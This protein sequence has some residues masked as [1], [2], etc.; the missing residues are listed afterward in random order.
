MIFLYNGYHIIDNKLWNTWLGKLKERGYFEGVEVN[1]EEYRERYQKAK[2]KFD[3]KFNSVKGN[4]SNEK[5]AEEFKL[6]GNQCLKDGEYEKAV[7]WYKKAIERCGAGKNSHIYYSNLA[8]AE[9]HLEDY[10]SAIEHCEKCIELCPDYCK[11][12][13]RLGFAHLKC[14]DMEQANDAYRRGLEIDPDNVAC[15]EGLEQ[16]VVNPAPK[17]AGMPD[18]SALAGMMGGGGGGLAGL[19]NNPAM[20]EMAAGMMQNPQMMQMAQNMMQNP[21]MMRNVMS[22]FGGGHPSSNDQPNKPALD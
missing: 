10:E 15:K 12:Y 17:D 3:Q 11:A 4:V 2:A 1:S 8:A 22:Q 9:T 21:D 13:S 5:E 7:E 18:L 19:M 16:A 6:S 20:K 14:G